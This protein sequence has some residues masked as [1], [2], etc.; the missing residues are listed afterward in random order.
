M[1]KSAAPTIF[2]ALKRV[3]KL[4]TVKEKEPRLLE[5]PEPERSRYSKR[6]NEQPSLF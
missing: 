1:I 6:V 5:P 2:C 3:I 4:D